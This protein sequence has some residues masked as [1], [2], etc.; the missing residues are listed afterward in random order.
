MSIH[1]GTNMVIERVWRTIGES[2]IVM[3]LTS[4][5]SEIF[6]EEAK[7]TSCFP[8]KKNRSPGA[9]TAN[10]PTS[11]YEQYYG[12]QQHVL[13]VKVFG[14]TC[15]TTRLDRAK[16]N[17]TSKAEVGIFG[18]YQEQQLRSWM[19]Y[20][21]YHD[22]FIITAHVH[23]EN[24]KLNKCD[25][26]IDSISSTITHPNHLKRLYEQNTSNTPCSLTL[27]DEIPEEGGRRRTIKA[28]CCIEESISFI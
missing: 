4:S 25:I 11:P 10:H 23:F 16:E 21:P 12:M 7:I 15:Y 24:D 14:S 2:A 9:H 19:I 17:H 18:G 13:H 8:K 20:L 26:Y 3:L 27:S 28:S 6:W 1:T 22:M 5:L